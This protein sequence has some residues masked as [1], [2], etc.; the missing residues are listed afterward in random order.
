MFGCNR[1]KGIPVWRKRLPVLLAIVAALCLVQ[2]TAAQS[3]SAGLP[4]LDTAI[5][6]FDDPNKPLMWASEIQVDDHCNPGNYTFARNLC[7]E[8][9]GKIT[10]PTAD[11]GLADDLALI[12]DQ[13]AD[14]V[15]DTRQLTAPGIATDAIIARHFLDGQIL[16]AHLDTGVSP[17][18]WQAVLGWP[19]A[20]GGLPDGGAINQWLRKKSGSDYDAE[21]ADLPGLTAAQ[22]RILAALVD[23]QG[24]TAGDNAVLM[25]WRDAEWV[26]ARIPGSSITSNPS[27]PYSLNLP[28]ASATQ[29]GILSAVDYARIGVHEDGGLASVATRDPVLGTGVA[30]DPVHLTPELVSLDRHYESGGWGAAAG[31]QIAAR[32]T[33]AQPV[34]SALSFGATWTNPGGTLLDSGYFPVAIPVERPYT[35]AEISVS[36]VQDEGDPHTNLRRT[37]DSPGV[38]DA[39][40]NAAG[41][42]QWYRVPIDGTFSVTGG[43]TYRVEVDDPSRLNIT[44]PVEDVEGLAGYVDEQ[45]ADHPTANVR[46]LFD[47][48]TPGVSVTSLSRDSA[49][50]K[51]NLAE[52][53]NVDT[54]PHGV[55]I[56]LLTPTANFVDTDIAFAETEYN[57]ETTIAAVAR[58]PP[59]NG[60]TQLG[61]VLISADLNKGPTLAG[62]AVIR[63]DR[64]ASGQVAGNAQYIHHEGHAL[65][66]SGSISFH[67]EIYLVGSEGARGETGGRW[68]DFETLPD[69]ASAFTDGDLILVRTGSGQGAYYKSSTETTNKA[70]TGLAGESLNPR[71]DLISNT[72]GSR[73]HVYFGRQARTNLPAGGT[74][75]GAPAAMTTLDFNY[76]ANTLDLG[77]FQI[78]YSS[79][80]SYSGAIVIT[81]GGP[82]HYAIRLT[83]RTA[84]LWEGSGLNAQQVAACRQYE[85]TFSEPGVTGY[86]VTHRLV[87]VLAG[88]DSYA[89]IH[90]V[91]WSG[92]QTL[93]LSTNNVVSAW[94]DIQTISLPAGL[95]HVWLNMHI[96]HGGAQS[97][98][99]LGLEVRLQ[100]NGVT[101]WRAPGMER[102]DLRG[103]GG[104]LAVKELAMVSGSGDYVLQVRGVAD[105]VA[106]ASP[107]TWTAANQQILVT[108]FGG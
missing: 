27:G 57:D 56:A 74:W 78:T 36:N 67:L 65:A 85:W 45:I 11:H 104:E 69:D 20:V 87:R 94:A 89:R 25:G 46:L 103:T 84:T 90:E 3:P 16:P 61:D 26:N 63:L 13:N 60:S 106:N 76:R 51:F 102:I 19:T 38:V 59:Y 7:V 98:A 64:D 71:T 47:G 82:I 24:L 92:N 23:P 12:Y 50:H 31:Y 58:A 72:D 28:V 107:V 37:L 105:L 96:T 35:L 29:A 75:S 77:V 97:G 34:W 88:A 8:L 18:Q 79:A 14:P 52:P 15:W 99:W 10:A 1:L 44:V 9:A 21:W 33:A 68:F 30:T 43:D 62:S 48:S 41:T 86:T 32:H 73:E 83:R 55:L 91:T 93:T 81:C 54:E 95:H 53:L 101:V 5:R 40:T 4:L 22:Q 70:D 6:G 39:G 80:R 108:T 42:A 17:A 100:R 2:I 66:D 49:I